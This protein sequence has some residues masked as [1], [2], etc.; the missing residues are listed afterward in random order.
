MCIAWH[1]ICQL[2]FFVFF[3][4]FASSF[5]SSIHD[6]F[7]NNTTTRENAAQSQK[8]KVWRWH[9]QEGGSSNDLQ[10]ARS[11]Q[12]TTG[13][14]QPNPPSWHARS[15]GNDER[16]PDRSGLRRRRDAKGQPWLGTDGAPG[17]DATSGYNTGTYYA[18]CILGVARLR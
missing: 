3:L 17:T 6:R 14:N 16:Q 5:V 18:T 13:P 8:I 2:S 9:R 7:I 11:R 15:E 10:N 1:H 12:G 4:C